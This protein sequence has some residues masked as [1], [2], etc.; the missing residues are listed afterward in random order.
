MN[1]AQA[2][3]RA[4]DAGRALSI[5]NEHAKRFPAGKLATARQVTRMVALCQAGSPKQARAEAATFLARNPSSP[6]A[7]R[8]RGIC[9]SE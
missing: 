7:E 1:G 3:L 5:L 4:G 9:S 2:A 8:V 6:F